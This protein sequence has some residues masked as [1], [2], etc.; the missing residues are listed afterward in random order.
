MTID[1]VENI[2]VLLR[3]R[4]PQSKYHNKQEERKMKAV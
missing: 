1:I 3:P 4:K 2:F